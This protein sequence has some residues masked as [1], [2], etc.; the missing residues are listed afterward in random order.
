MNPFTTSNKRDII[1]PAAFAANTGLAA[2]PNPQDKTRLQRAMGKVLDVVFGAPDSSPAPL[3]HRSGVDI[4][5]RAARPAKGVVLLNAISQAIAEFHYNEVRPYRD[6]TPNL[7]FQLQQVCLIRTADNMALVQDF[8]RLRSEQR[9]T[10]VKSKVKEFEGFDLSELSDVRITDELSC[11]ADPVM[12]VAGEGA[13]RMALRV[14]FH[15]EFIDLPAPATKPQGVAQ[16]NHQPSLLSSQTQTLLVPSEVARPSRV[17]TL[18]PYPVAPE[19]PTL[20]VLTVQEPGQP[21]RQV[22]LG[23]FPFSIGRGED[24]DL[25]L[26]NG[27]ASRMHLTLIHDTQSHSFRV[28]DQST[29][30]TLLGTRALARQEQ[31]ALPHGACLVLAPSA[32]DGGIQLRIQILA[33][34]VAGPVQPKQPET[35]PVRADNPVSGARQGAAPHAATL[36]VNREPAAAAGTLVQRTE[37]PLHLQDLKS[38]P[39]ARLR[40]RTDGGESQFFDL[41]DLPFEIGRE[42]ADDN[43][44][45]IEERHAKVSRLHLR[46]TKQQAGVFVVQNLAHGSNGTWSAGERQGERFTIKAVAPGSK[47]GWVFLGDKSLSHLSAAVRLEQLT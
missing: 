7:V 29:A 12:V 14:E 22:N 47:D 41:T 36:V 28:M 37:P 4:D 6:A 30:G 2:M 27:Y 38:L 10:I 46:I 40:V 8:G 32:P 20:M 43:C 23:K 42:P 33:P 35:S 3:P 34:K 19:K 18:V 44:Y 17:A 16:A 45:C 15:G 31:V 9:V 1:P 24:C 39:L 25:V 26:T 5:A 21:E 13:Q 11:S